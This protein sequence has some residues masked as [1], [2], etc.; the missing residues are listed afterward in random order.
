MWFPDRFCAHISSSQKPPDSILLGFRARFGAKFPLARTRWIRYFRYLETFWVDFA[1]KFFQPKPSQGCAVQQRADPIPGL[2]VPLGPLPARPSAHPS[3][4]ARPPVRPSAR[5]PVRSLRLGPRGVG[6]QD[7]L[8]SSV[9]EVQKTRKL[10]RTAAY[11]YLRSLSHAFVSG[12]EITLGDFAVPSG[13]II[14]PFWCGNFAHRHD[15]RGCVWICRERPN[16]KP[17]RRV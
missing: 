13:C 12:L 4:S 14:R 10:Q 16:P 15:N 6:P 11:L 1:T 8:S 3:V 9:R 17:S 2:G 5:P 7:D